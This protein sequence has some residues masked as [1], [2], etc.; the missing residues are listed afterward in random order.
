MTFYI[1]KSFAVRNSMKNTIR[2]CGKKEE[3]NASHEEYVKKVIV[4]N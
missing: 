1:P 3:R 4:K 2:L